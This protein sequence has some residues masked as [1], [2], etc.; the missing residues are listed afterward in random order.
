MYHQF[1]Y[2]YEPNP[3]RTMIKADQGKCTL[4]GDKLSVSGSTHELVCLHGA[5]EANRS[6]FTKLRDKL[7]TNGISSLAFDFI[8]HGESGGLSE[9]DSLD[10]RLEQAVQVIEEYTDGDSLSILATSMSAYTAIGV[11]EC[12]SVDNFILVVPAIYHFKADGVPFDTGFSDIIRQ[13]HSWLNTASW[14]TLENFRGNLLVVTA[15]HDA[16]IPTL[17]PQLIMDFS[18]QANYKKLMEVSGSS[19]QLLE[20]IN[21]NPPVLDHLATEIKQLLMQPDNSSSWSLL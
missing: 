5:G 10:S 8:G 1:E 7:A 12:V 11:T 9:K 18:I 6:R 2:D 3:M 17:I 20:F 14:S 13:P 19:H 16:V 4:V 15:E 21:S